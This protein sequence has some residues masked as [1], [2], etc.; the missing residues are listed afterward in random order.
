MPRRDKASMTPGE[1]R[2]HLDRSMTERDFQQQIIDLATT[3]GYW[4]HH[5]PDSRRSTPGWPDLVLMRGGE[6][7]RLYFVEVKKEKGRVT[8]E[9]QMVLDLLTDCGQNA[10]VW[11]P[12]MW[13]DIM[14]TLLSS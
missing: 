2:A 14:V 1:L 7:P 8:R 6:S 11:R 13:P 10:Y 9:Q 12:S 5:T 4:V 3:L